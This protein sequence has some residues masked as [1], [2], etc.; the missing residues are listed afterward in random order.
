MEFDTD[1][2]KEI[3]TYCI[4]DEL[5]HFEEWHDVELPLEII[6]AMEV[7]EK[8]EQTNCMLYRLL[9]LGKNLGFTKI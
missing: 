6:P 5:D 7:I 2:L 9:I 3:Y 4:D 1:N 8:M